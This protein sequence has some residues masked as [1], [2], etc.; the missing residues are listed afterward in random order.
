MFAQ[1]AEIHNALTEAAAFNQVSSCFLRKFISENKTVLI[2]L[3]SVTAS[4]VFCDK[5]KERRN[6]NIDNS[7][8]RVT[9]KKF[10]KKKPRKYARRKKNLKKPECSV[11]REEHLEVR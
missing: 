1:R 7:F 2:D 3:F 10:I 6:R 9:D 8:N 5:R 4:N 11:C